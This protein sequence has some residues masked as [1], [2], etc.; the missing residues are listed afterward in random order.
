M[1]EDVRDVSAEEVKAA[2]AA[3]NISWIDCHECSGCGRMVGYSVNQGRLYFNS[4]CGCSWSP[5]EPRAWSY[6]AD[7][8][9]MQSRP[10]IKRKIA[11]R[12]GVTLP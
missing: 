11:A 3:G 8:V 7:W 10:D 12:F 2:V 5:A 1:S 6:A 4:G 9:N